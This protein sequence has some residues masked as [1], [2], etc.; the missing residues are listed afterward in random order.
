MI[1]TEIASIRGDEGGYLHEAQL[2]SGHK[3]ATKLR[4]NI[5]G[6]FTVAVMAALR[7]SK[8]GCI[9]LDLAVTIGLKEAFE[10]PNVVFADQWRA[11]ARPW[12]SPC[13]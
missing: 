11:Y 4:L 8:N 1:P 13:Q 3:K 6:D 5:V 12:S 10:K 2:L 7:N 9:A